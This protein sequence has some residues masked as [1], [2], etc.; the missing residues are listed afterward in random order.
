MNAKGL[1]G[2]VYTMTLVVY[3]KWDDI[4]SIQGTV[5][6]QKVTI[7]SSFIDIGNIN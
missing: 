5:F 3:E 1:L 2:R 6:D 7:F 4:D